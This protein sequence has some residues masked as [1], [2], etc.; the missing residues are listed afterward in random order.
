MYRRVPRCVELSRYS[1]SSSIDTSEHIHLAQ[2]HPEVARVAWRYL[3][4]SSGV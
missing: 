3:M 4:V 1:V 2:T